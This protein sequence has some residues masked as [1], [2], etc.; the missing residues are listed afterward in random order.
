MSG[1]YR[2][3]SS[4]V[5][6]HVPGVGRIAVALL[7]IAPAACARAQEARPIGSTAGTWAFDY[8]GRHGSGQPLLDLRS[9]NEKEAGQSGFV[10]LTP[11]GNGF[12]LG[13]GTPA[14]FWSIGSEVYRQSPGDLIRHVRF[15]AG[16]G[17]N[18]VRLHTQL[19]PKEQGSRITEV[20]SKEIDGIWRF[21]AAA[22]KQGI[23]TAISPYW[24]NGK[25]TAGWGIGGYSGTTDLWGLLFFDET[26]QG[27]YKAW[28]RALYAPTNP[29]TGI[30]LSRDPAV[31]LIQVQNEDSL[32]FW[33]TMGIK[34]AQQER[35]GKKFGEWL[36]RKYGSIGE[37]SRAWKGVG[38][39]EDDL[40]RGRVGLFNVWHMTRPQTGGMAGRIAD[41]LAFYAETQRRFYAEM[42]GYYRDELGCRQL[43]NA[44]NWK[45]ADPIKLDEVE[46]WTYTAADVVAVNRY[47]NGGVHVGDNSGWRVD[48]GHH[49]SQQSALLNPR[50]LPINVKQV[51]G[52]PLI[53]SES[54]WVTPLA[55][56][57]EGP[58]L[59]AVYQSLTGVDAFSW[60]TAPVPEYAMDP[61]HNFTSIN[62]QHPLYKWVAS[63]PTI[64]GGFPAAALMYRRGYIKQGEPVVHEERTVANLWDR[65][66]PIIAEDRSFDPNRD[67]G[68]AVGPAELKTGVDPLAFLVGPVEVTY[69]GDP[70]KTRVVDLSRYIDRTNKTIGSNTGEITLDY[71]NGL[72]TLDTPRAQGA[73]GFLAKAGAI[74]LGDVAIRSRNGYATVAVVSMDDLP[75]ASSR[76]ILV[77]VGTSARPTGWMTREAEFPGED[78]KTLVRGFQV[79]KTGTPPWRV[80]NTEVGLVV[81]NPGL[82]KATLLDTAGYPVQEVPGTRAGDDFSLGFPLNTMYLILESAAG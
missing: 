59:I 53:F 80:V 35:L 25:N 6:R 51:V 72:C 12:A 8:P 33:T 28:V 15:L 20:D 69:D 77:Q 32:L 40:A 54:S 3:T 75:L 63:I 37:A 24:A 34:P 74:R 58:F 67:R 46:R 55:Y 73:C 38:H 81:R 10:R 57:S 43:I 60:F 4:P 16:I 14:R 21:V 48:P 31:A 62:G 68:N 26:L 50:E 64:M 56:Q 29:H 39:A 36:V 76:K 49:F 18:L 66:P 23:Y 71:G 17:V 70:A 42:V 65:D 30:P 2:T 82:T 27:G 22:K 1:A 79:V 13:D 11:D 52:H 41:E 5:R 78:G 61:F 9:L 7:A 47:Y 44:C 19:A 45:T